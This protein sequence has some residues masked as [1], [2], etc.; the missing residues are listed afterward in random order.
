[1]KGTTGI[2][3]PQQPRYTPGLCVVKL[4]RQEDT[5][6]LV[7]NIL[8]P[9]EINYAW[10]LMSYELCLRSWKRFITWKSLEYGEH[11]LI[12]PFPLDSL[13]PD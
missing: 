4:R 1:M 12:V 13:Y 9:R 10:A 8:K 2:G 5:R 6:P 3:V 7:C 11:H